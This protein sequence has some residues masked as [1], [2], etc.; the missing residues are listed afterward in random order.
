MIAGLAAAGLA[1][2]E[3]KYV[4]AATKAAAFVLEHQRTQEGR[5]LRTYGAQPGQEP[6]A[7]V[8]G[9]LEDYAFLAHGLLNLHDATKDRHWLADARTI[10]DTMIAF[11]GAKKSGGYYFTASDGE[12]FF[13][14]SKDQF[15]GAQ[16][17]ANSLAARNLVRLWAATGE[18][19]YRAEAERTFRALAGSPQRVSWRACPFLGSPALDLYMDAVAKKNETR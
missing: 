9:Y 14:R 6:K 11:H 16:P 3:P 13:A 8:A 12:K 10:T 1:L 17:A 15:D 7:A 19:K 2:D 5:L 18:D 4:E